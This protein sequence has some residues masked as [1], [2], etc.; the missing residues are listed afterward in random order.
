MEATRTSQWVLGPART[1]G[2]RQRFFCSFVLSALLHLG[3][4]AAFFC[5]RHG[6]F[7]PA[8]FGME[9]RPATLSVTW[10]ETAVPSPPDEIASPSP[11]R[12]VEVEQQPAPQKPEPAVE[13]V[14]S[15]EPAKAVAEATAPAAPVVERPPPVAAPAAH[16]PSVAE[17]MASANAVASPGHDV[18]FSEAVTEAKPDH[19]RNPRPQYPRLARERGWEGAARL[20]IEVLANGLAGQI[21]VVRSSGHR[22]LDEVSVETVRQHWKF[23]PARRGDTPVDW[24]VEQDIVFQ[25]RRG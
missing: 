22:I 13:P 8:E 10:I 2:G 19:L 16:L 4:L 24:W 3:V 11:S 21:E 15:I 20:R 17:P 7:R 5:L 6:E 1:T 25:L 9:D 12:T 23:L 14:A 18:A